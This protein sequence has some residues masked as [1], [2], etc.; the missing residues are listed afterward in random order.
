[1]PPNRYCPNTEV[2]QFYLAFS[3]LFAGMIGVVMI[4]MVFFFTSLDSP[5]WILGATRLTDV[6]V[7]NVTTVVYSNGDF[8]EAIYTNDDHIIV[9]GM[10]GKRI[11]SMRIRADLEFRE[12]LSDLYLRRGGRVLIV[13]GNST[14]LVDEELR[15]LFLELAE[16]NRKFLYA[17]V[18]FMHDNFDYVLDEDLKEELR[19]KSGR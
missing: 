18:I 4:I 11:P 7:E 19:R 6:M 15:S 9:T 3:D 12:Y 16:T 5:R 17:D 10:S 8:N 13:I 2:D 14:Y 1:M